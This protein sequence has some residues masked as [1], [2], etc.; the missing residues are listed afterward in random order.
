M[1]SILIRHQV[2]HLNISRPHAPRIREPMKHNYRKVVTHKTFR[3]RK[4]L[5]ELQFFSLEK[6][7]EGWLKM[8]KQAKKMRMICFPCLLWRGGM[9]TSVA[10]GIQMRH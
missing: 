9:I 6:I 8:W 3:M 1:H 4:K 10:K 7:E 2:E 5:N